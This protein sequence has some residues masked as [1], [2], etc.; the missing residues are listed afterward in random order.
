MF[1]VGLALDICVRY[2][3]DDGH[4]SGFAAAVVEDACLAIDLA[5][6]LTATRESLAGI[7]V[8]LIS[9]SMICET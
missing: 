7:D 5:E 1:L 4:R 9:S 2:S 3:V 8:P 6:S